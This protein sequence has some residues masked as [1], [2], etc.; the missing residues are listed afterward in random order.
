MGGGYGL[1]LQQFSPEKT[2][3]VYDEQFN[4][5]VNLINRYNERFPGGQFSAV[6]V[7]N[8]N[9]IIAHI[10]TRNYGALGANSY[11]TGSITINNCSVQNN[12]PSKQYRLRI[13]VKRTGEDEWRI[14][15]MSN[16]GVPASIDF[17]VQ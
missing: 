4:I 11:S 7:D 17:T 5:S 2:S 12:V 6:L 16:D 8:N 3:V 1:V 13:A 10:G 9:L 15:N 14:A